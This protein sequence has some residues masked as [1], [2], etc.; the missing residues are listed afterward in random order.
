VRLVVTLRDDRVPENGC[1]RIESAP[2]VTEHVV[3]IKLPGAAWP[4]SCSLV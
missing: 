2:L 3:I 1:I 4:D